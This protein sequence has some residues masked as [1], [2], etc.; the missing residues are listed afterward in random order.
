MLALECIAYV[1]TKEREGIGRHP[2]GR[3]TR[4]WIEE[5]GGEQEAVGLQPIGA[6]QIDGN[7]NRNWVHIEIHA[8][9]E[10]RYT[11]CMVEMDIGVTM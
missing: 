7:A 1:R 8:E 6:I 2:Y 4:V 10:H 3:E 5:V 11:P 9:Q